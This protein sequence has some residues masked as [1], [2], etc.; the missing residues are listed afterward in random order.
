MTHIHLEL[1]ARGAAQPIPRAPA[2]PR[3]TLG[4]NPAALQAAITA[5][6]ATI[7][8]LEA[9]WAEASEGAVARSTRRTQ[10]ADRETWDRNTWCRYLNAAAACQDRYLPRLR[11]LYAEAARLEHLQMTLPAAPGRAA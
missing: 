2:C 5:K 4:F 1:G 9:E 7:A 10:L 11:R 6:R 3:T 8:I